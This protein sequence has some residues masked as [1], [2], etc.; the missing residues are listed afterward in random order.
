MVKGQSHDLQV[1]CK[2]RMQALIHELGRISRLT[3]S[4]NPAQDSLEL[5]HVC[6]AV[7]LTGERHS[8]FYQHLSTSTNSHAHSHALC[9]PITTAAT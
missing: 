6:T 1:Q 5:G 2:V 7:I 9:L 8:A 3:Q 4:I